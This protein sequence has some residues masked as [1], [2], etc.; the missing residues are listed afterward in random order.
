MKLKLRLPAGKIFEF[1][2]PLF[3]EK[4]VYSVKFETFIDAVEAKFELTADQREALLN[5]WESKDRYLVEC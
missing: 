3:A 4:F 1:I 5:Q 2:Y